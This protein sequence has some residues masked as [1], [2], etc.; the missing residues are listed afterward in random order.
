VL[1]RLGVQDPDSF[2]LVEAHIVYDYEARFT[3]GAVELE[4]LA[5]RYNLILHRDILHL[6][7]EVLPTPRAARAAMA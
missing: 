5:M 7:A 2:P 6:L 1:Q 3:W 4:L